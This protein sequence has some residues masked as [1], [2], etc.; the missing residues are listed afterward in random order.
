VEGEEHS[1]MDNVPHEF[2]SLKSQVWVTGSHMYGLNTPDS[3][4][5]YT[6]V[7]H[8]S[9]YLCPLTDRD[10][11]L[12][13]SN[14]EGDDFVAHTASKFARLVVK[15]NFN[16]LDLLF[17]EAVVK[18]EFI[19][20]YVEAVRPHAITRNVASA[21]MGYVSSQKHSALIHPRPQSP[22][23][24]EEIARL[25]YDPKFA[26]HLIRGVFTLGR[27][28]ETGEYHYLTDVEKLICKAVKAGQWD[29]DYL[30]K[31]VDAQVGKLEKLYDVASDALPD[32]TVVETVT[33]DHFIFNS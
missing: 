25:G 27:I 14:A 23:R 16:T 3:D 20:R 11:T 22:Q 13:I 10:R 24:K 31:Y 6:G 33:C 28:L 17:H 30:T 1:L 2:S 21:Y 8:P 32:A 7:F 12:T 15:G 4:Y 19:Q 18:Q 29:R 9:D 26:S 5:D